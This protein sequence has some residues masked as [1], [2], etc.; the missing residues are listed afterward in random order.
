[1]NKTARFSSLRFASMVTLALLAASGS[2]IAQP[3]TL[4]EKPAGEPKPQA[5]PVKAAEP[6]SWPDS[7]FV[8]EPVTLVGTGFR[9]VEG[10]AWVPA[11]GQGA[12]AASGYFVFCAVPKSEVY[13]WPAEGKPV[14]A[15][16][17]EPV[18]WRAPSE[19]A[20]GIAHESGQTLLF[21]EVGQRRITRGT[22]KADGTWEIEVIADKFEGKRLNDT[23]DLAVMPKGAKNAGR[24]YFT[25]PR[26]FTD[27]KE[28]EQAGNAV[29]AC[30]PQASDPVVK[31]A[32]AT[33][34]NG[35]AISPDGKTLYVAEF[36]LGQIVSYALK[37]DGSATDRKVLADMKAL[38]KEHGITGRTIADGLRTDAQ[39]RIF[40]AGPGGIW[41][42]ASD[43]KLLGHLP[44]PSTN[45]ALGGADGKTIFLTVDGGKVGIAKLK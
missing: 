20:L 2:A 45:F 21:A 14:D 25:D 4:T 11:S 27:R 9:C 42:F 10:P 3:G 39:G 5:E 44:Q 8:D 15:S 13:R 35:V 1:M 30:G 40:C 32:D 18:L 37:D 28:I 12:S 17:G 33:L 26:F 23:N 36:G 29:Y 7:P 6:K 16:G 24:I 43:G 41:A 38:A 31:I 19:R 34:P 22:R